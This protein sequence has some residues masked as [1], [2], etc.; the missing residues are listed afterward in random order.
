MREPRKTQFTSAEQAVKAVASNDDVLLANFCAEPHVLPDKL[1]DRAKEVEN[2][3]FFHLTPF[4]SFQEKYLL[5]GMEKH[6]K[7]S[8]AFCGRR[9]VPRKLIR[10]GRADFYPLT[11]VNIPKMFKAGDFKCNVVMLTVSPPDHDGYCNLG[12]SV[13]YF[14][15][16]LEQ[17]PR[18]IIAEINKNM[19]RTCGKTA[20]HIS[21]IDYAVENN[22]PI[23]ELEQYPIGEIEE[24]IGANVASIVEDGSTLQIGYGGISEAVTYFLQEKNDLGVHSEM[25]PEGLRHIAANGCVTGAKKSINQGKIVCTFHGGTKKLYDWLHE[26]PIIEMLP[27]EY[28]NDPKI[29]AQNSKMVA[30]NS[31]LQVDLFGNIYSD[32]F[33]LDDQYT[34]SGGLL[35]F[36]IGCA[37]SDDA[38]FISAIPSTTHNGNV[39]RIVVHPTFETNNPN[40]PIVSTVPRYY[41]DYVITEYGIARLK[42]KPNTERARELIEIAHPDFRALLREDAKKVGLLS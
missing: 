25:I 38:K 40:I 24:K 20:V 27:V 9:Q 33:G 15:A 34:G 18:L 13:D 31:A 12:V 36:A 32:L 8:T 16:A 11:F 6:I 19:P 1:M 22:E 5:P 3:R 2:V 14:W 42:G 17:E 29:I 7:C 21:Q 4:G 41:S 35:D 26:N 28:V 37:I 23:F 10:E 30:I 39:S